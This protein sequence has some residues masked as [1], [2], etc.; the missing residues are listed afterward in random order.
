[1]MLGRLR[2]CLQNRQDSIPSRRHY[3]Q[4]WAHPPWAR[5][6]A[7]SLHE[8]TERAVRTRT[9][10]VDG[11]QSRPV[12]IAGHGTFIARALNGLGCSGLSWAFQQ[13]MPMPAV[14]RLWFGRPTVY[15]ARPLTHNNGAGDGMQRAPRPGGPDS[16]GSAVF[17]RS[18][19][20]SATAGRRG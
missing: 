4:S 8:L 3:A 5:P 16:P 20:G 1:M 17:P 10:I 9:D 11:L 18:S 12:I 15:A 19:A 7:E 13:A 14:Y 2:Y 6:G